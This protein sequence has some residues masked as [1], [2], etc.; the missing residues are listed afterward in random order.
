MQLQLP[1]HDNYKYKCKY[2]TL[3]YTNYTAL[4]QLHYTTLITLHYANY[5]TVR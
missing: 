1:Y 2:A 4:H 5:S 3:Q